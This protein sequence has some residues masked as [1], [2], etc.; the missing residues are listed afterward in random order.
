M[1]G[2][3][4]SFN[5]FKKNEILPSIFFPN[6]NSMKQNRLQEAGKPKNVWWLNN[7]LLNNLLGQRR[8]KRS[9]ATE[10]NENKN[11]TY[12]N[13]T[14]AAKATLKEKFIALQS[15]LKKENLK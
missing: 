11:I 13:F 10:T 2:H 8:N 15:Y 1:L 6:H 5:K 3:N 12:Q 9:K 7:M 4:T 14:D